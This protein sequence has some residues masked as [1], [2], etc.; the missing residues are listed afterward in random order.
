M[1]YRRLVPAFLFCRHRGDSPCSRLER[2]SCCFAWNRIAAEALRDDIQRGFCVHFCHAPLRLRIKCWR[3][4][5]LCKSVAHLLCKPP[6][7]WQHREQVPPFPLVGRL[8]V[9]S[10]FPYFTIPKAILYGKWLLSRTEHRL[11]PPLYGKAHRFRT[12]SSS[13]R[14]SIR[15]IDAIF[16]TS[17]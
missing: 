3:L 13:I 2:R 7:P 16:P 14:S 4:G 12:I 1:S 11:M 9:F 8:F 17:L 15:P 6:V 5:S 10:R